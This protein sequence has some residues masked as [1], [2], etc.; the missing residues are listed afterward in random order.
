VKRDL[1]LVKCVARSRS[2]HLM[3][4]TIRPAGRLRSAVLERLPDELNRHRQLLHH[5]PRLQPQHAIP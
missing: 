5:Q 3:S 1:A 4:L 2:A